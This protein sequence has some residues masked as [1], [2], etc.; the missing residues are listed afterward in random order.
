[1]DELM[2]QKKR[3]VMEQSSSEELHQRPDE[4]RVD[5]LYASPS[6]L[7]KDDNAYKD[8]IVTH[9]IGS[10]DEFESLDKLRSKVIRRYFERSIHT[11]ETA[12]E[13]VDRYDVAEAKE[14]REINKERIKSTH[15]H[16]YAKTRKSK[17]KTSA[18]KMRL[19]S[20]KIGIL[21]QKKDSTEDYLSL[22]EK[23]SGFADI[24][25]T[26]RESDRYFAESFAKSKLEENLIKAKADR[27]YYIS[28]KEL[29][30]KQKEQ[31]AF[32]VSQE[33]SKLT[34]GTLTKTQ[35]KGIKDSLKSITKK[36]EEYGAKIAEYAELATATLHKIDDL[37]EKLE[38]AGSRQ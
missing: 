25:S 33:E 23:V 34:G 27:R 38:S 36:Q 20:E 6:V 30:I 21:K 16:R 11:E 29:Y 12:L 10:N 22:E 13:Q 17:M 31:L 28:M 18:E 19:V 7:A 32:N 14:N 5:R 9:A 35:I 15:S 2:Q 37:K 8:L 24:Y 1:M 3:E 4:V 26:I